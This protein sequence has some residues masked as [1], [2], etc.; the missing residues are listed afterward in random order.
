MGLDILAWLIYVRK[1]ASHLPTPISAVCS[2]LLAAKIADSTESVNIMPA[3]W[4]KQNMPLLLPQDD[5]VRFVTVAPG[6]FCKRHALERMP[7]YRKEWERTKINITRWLIKT[8]SKS[9]KHG[10][11]DDS[12]GLQSIKRAQTRNTTPRFLEQPFNSFRN[13]CGNVMLMR[14]E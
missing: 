4:Q 14:T 6:Q 3:S 2:L 10:I 1:I 8:L 12:W 11:C 9:F 5:G 7:P 13:L